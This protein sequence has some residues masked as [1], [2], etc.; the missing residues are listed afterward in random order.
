MIQNIIDQ[1]NM[2]LVYSYFLVK[3]E[4]FY[5]KVVM[6]NLDYF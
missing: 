3:N 2:L 4:V 6:F 1:N 5:S